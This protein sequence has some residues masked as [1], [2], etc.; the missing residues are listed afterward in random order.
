MG[1]VRGESG[2]TIS[3]AGRASPPFVGLRY[4][5]E[6]ESPPS[7]QEQEWSGAVHAVICVRWMPVYEEPLESDQVTEVRCRSLASGGASVD[8]HDELSVGSSVGRCGR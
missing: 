5:D 6:V 4:A 8:M 3:R 7:R 2:P 1:K